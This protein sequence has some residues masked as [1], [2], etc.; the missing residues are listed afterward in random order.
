VDAQNTSVGERNLREGARVAAFGFGVNIVLA[1]AKLLAGWF[2]NSYALI[3]DGIES[4]LDIGGSAAM[5][6]GLRVASRPPDES[7]PYG[8]GKAE[9]MA[10]IAVAGV[11]LAAATGL[12]VQSIRE[13]GVPHHAPANFTLV[14]LVFVI[15]IKELLFRVV[16]R[17]GHRLGSNAV[18]ADAIHHRSDSI[19]SVAAFIGIGISLIG[20]E[21]YESADD[22]AALAACGWIAY[23]GLSLLV[24]AF[25]EL[26]DTAPPREL[27]EGVRQVAE[28]TEGVVEVE[29]CLM[30][31]MG[32]DLYVDIHVRV[33]AVL[34]VREGHRIAHAVKDAVRK[35]YPTVADVLVHVEP[36]E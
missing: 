13:I 1:A 33:S 25:R 11:V 34:T 35:K 29:K 26:M 8:H 15:L 24:P 28:R 17:I 23:N 21:G 36:A 22:W 3:A 19:T 12:A 20:G 32:L 6:A 5:W 18:K 14:V 27:V 10:A 30:R 7:H 9:P 31:K 4:T 2:G 16:M